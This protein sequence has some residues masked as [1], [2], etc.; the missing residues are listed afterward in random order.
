MA[1]LVHLFRHYD[2][3]FVERRVGER[4]KEGDGCSLTGVEC[5]GERE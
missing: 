2:T 1:R 5:M 3:S 4:R